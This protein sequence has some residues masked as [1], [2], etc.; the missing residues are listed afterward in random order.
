MTVQRW[1]LHEILAFHPRHP[2]N[3]AYSAG[4]TTLECVER[5]A[6]ATWMIKT[7]LHNYFPS[8]S[9][10][11]VFRVFR[12]LGYSRLV[13][14]ELARICTW[15]RPS[16]TNAAREPE[17]TDTGIL[18]YPRSAA[19]ALPQGAP[20]SG[21]LANAATWRL[22]VSLSEFA[23]RNNL[24]YTRYSDDMAFSSAKPF[25]RGTAAAQIGE[26]TRIVTSLGFDLHER[27]TK[28]IP[29]GARKM[30][31]GMLITDEGVAILPEHRRRIELYIHC[32][33]RYGPVSFAEARN[34][35]S[36]IS[37]INHVEGWLAYLAHI[38]IEWTR[39]RSIEWSA[40]LASHQVYSNV[41][42]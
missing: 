33:S 19:A 37:L 39:S 36:A 38:D 27:K 1:I 32:V 24:V 2:N 29:P 3:F 16:G 8:V 23:A 20:T 5:H 41:L 30:L 9:E 22:D 42:E 4:V 12:K 40:A 17:T 6:G 34:F 18:P 31:L 15:T 21:A 11:D 14:F 25:D 13:A 10:S 35:D 26:I 28:I 7:D